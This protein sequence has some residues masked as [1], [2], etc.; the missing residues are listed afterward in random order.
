[1]VSYLSSD[2]HYTI[3]LE[4]KYFHGSFTLKFFLTEPE[5]GWSSSDLDSYHKKQAGASSLKHLVLHRK[6]SSSPY[7][8]VSSKEVFHV[9]STEAGHA[10]T[11]ILPA[12]RSRTIYI[13]SSLP[14]VLQDYL[15]SKKKK[16]YNNNSNN[17]NNNF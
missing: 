9:I 8:K 7:T 16:I 13:A 2:N 5:N 17:N 1:M 15:V 14:P 11:D 3:F 10:G 12:L 4:L 6:F